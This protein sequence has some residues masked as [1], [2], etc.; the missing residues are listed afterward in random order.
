MSTSLRRYTEL[1]F[2]IDLLRTNEVA[3]VSPNTW[4]D[5]NDAYYIDQYARAKSVPVTYA[6][7]LA[8]A[9]ETYHHWKVFSSGSGGVCVVFKKD[10]LLCAARKIPEV[11]AKSV[12][13]KTISQLKSVRPVEE[14]LPFLKRYAFR[15]ER[16]F[17]LFV[18]SITDVGPTYRIRISHSVIDRIV[19]SPWLPK[20]VVSHVRKTL[21]T[22]PGCSRL[23]VT[24]STLV[25]NEQWK[26][27]AAYST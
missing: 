1:P 18:G 25:E 26:R 5:R 12:K 23:R 16:E 21:R 7:C 14:D 9:Q 22:I 20:S 10:A 3:L 19:L 24:R 2:A 4:D 8:E 6:L 11:Q 17:R 13:Y 27:Y 15:D